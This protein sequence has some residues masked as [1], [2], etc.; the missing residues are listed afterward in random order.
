MDIL[1]SK[2]QIKEVMNLKLN[3][4]FSSLRTSYPQQQCTLFNQALRGSGKSI[5]LR[6]LKGNFYLDFLLKIS[7]LLSSDQNIYSDKFGIMLN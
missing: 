3:N 6:L 1:L 4:I 2:I 5:F 7:L